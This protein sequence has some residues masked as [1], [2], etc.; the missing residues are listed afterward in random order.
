MLVQVTTTTTEYGEDLGRG[1]LRPFACCVTLFEK[2]SDT[3]SERS[4][5]LSWDV[6]LASAN[7]S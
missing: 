4:Q 7:I 6:E 3:N 2:L 5:I 1:A